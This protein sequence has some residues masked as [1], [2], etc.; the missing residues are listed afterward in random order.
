MVNSII[1]KIINEVE[2]HLVEC[3]KIRSKD[4]ALKILLI[5]LRNMLIPKRRLLLHSGIHNGCFSQI[6]KDTS[7][8]SFL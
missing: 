3:F 2:Y 7:S 1:R 8:G 6:Y 5:P 4:M